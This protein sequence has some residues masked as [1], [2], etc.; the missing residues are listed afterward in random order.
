MMLKNVVLLL[1]VLSLAGC[2]TTNA[3]I[4]TE[5]AQHYQNPH[6]FLVDKLTKGMFGGL[7]KNKLT[8]DGTII[9]V[10]YY[11]K[12]NQKYL[13][14]P[15]EDAKGYCLATGGQWKTVAMKTK[16]IGYWQQVANEQAAIRVAAA[17]HGVSG[18]AVE[19]KALRDNYARH[20]WYYENSDLKIAQQ[21][22]NSAARHGLLGIFDCLNGEQ[23]WRVVINP[24]KFQAADPSNQLT[25]HKIT[26]LVKAAYKSTL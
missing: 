25:T 12:T 4:T 21:I 19:R 9:Y 10:A 23:S 24:T 13:R 18:S 26:L 7:D 2:L 3:K 14:K 16:D 11:T 20:S 1:T 5:E 17:Q 8:R 6:D 22:L 15:G